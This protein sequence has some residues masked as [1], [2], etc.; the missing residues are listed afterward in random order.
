[1]IFNLFI[2]LWT[3]LCAISIIIMNYIKN[4]NETVV[5]LKLTICLCSDTKNNQ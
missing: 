2:L 3:T 5:N 4:Y 1:M